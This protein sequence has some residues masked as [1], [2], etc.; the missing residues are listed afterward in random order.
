MFAP[1]QIQARL[2]DAYAAGRLD[3]AMRLLVET[4][5]AMRPARDLAL[6][7]AIAGEAL[8]RETPAALSP[9]ALLQ[10]LAKIDARNLPP[11]R[12]RPYAD[13]VANLPEPL[14]AAALEALQEHGWTFGGPGVRILPLGLKDSA[15]AEL[16]RIEP[17]YGVP[18][19]THDA[20]EYTLVLTGAF[21]DERG[22][23]K[24]GDISFAD[25]SVTHTPTAEQGDICWNLAVSE[26]PLKLT[27]ALGV[28][29]RMLPN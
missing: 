4:Q 20:G 14:R 19:H 18:N 6:A 2:A 24:P 23:Y 9:D 29:Q 11:P 17:G 21:H 26:A 1:E 8:E 15:L 13:E 3:A 28:M 27:G 7:E 22:L 10:T 12:R 25:P 16:I 5:A